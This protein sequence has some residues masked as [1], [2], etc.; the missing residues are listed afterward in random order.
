[1]TKWSRALASF[2]EVSGWSIGLN[3][4]FFIMYFGLDVQPEIKVW[5]F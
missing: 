2:W 5:T 1:M 3:F 4:D